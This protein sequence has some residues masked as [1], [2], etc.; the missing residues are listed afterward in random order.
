MKV[1]VKLEVSTSSGAFAVWQASSNKVNRIRTKTLMQSRNL[2]EDLLH[3]EPFTIV[4]S[5]KTT[6]MKDMPN[7]SVKLC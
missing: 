7:K 1:R 5:I 2:K 3:I 4:T 6:N